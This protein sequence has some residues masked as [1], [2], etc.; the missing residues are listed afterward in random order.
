MMPLQLLAEAS[1]IFHNDH[2]WAFIEKNEE[3]IL[4]YSE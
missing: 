3:N 2:D 4:D 1:W